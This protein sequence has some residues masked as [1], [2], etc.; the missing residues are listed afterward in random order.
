MNQSAFESD[1]EFLLNAPAGTFKLSRMMT[2]RRNDKG[3]Y[4][5]EELRK[6]CDAWLGAMRSLNWVVRLRLSRTS[7]IGVKWVLPETDFAEIR[8]ADGSTLTLSTAA[9]ETPKREYGALAYRFPTEGEH[10]VIK[11]PPSLIAILPLL[12]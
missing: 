3:Q 2:I 8:S 10:P 7:C 1:A 4:T 11:A 9:V 6:G 12:D 5:L